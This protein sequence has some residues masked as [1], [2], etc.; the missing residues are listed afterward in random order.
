MGYFSLQDPSSGLSYTDVKQVHQMMVREV[1]S[2][3]GGVGASAQR[4]SLLQV[5]LLTSQFFLLWLKIY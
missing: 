2:L 1:N 5:S 4:H 3:R